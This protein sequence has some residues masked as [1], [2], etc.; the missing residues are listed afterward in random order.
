MKNSILSYVKRS[1]YLYVF[2]LLMMLGSIALDAVFP[3]ITRA[4]IDD[5]VIAGNIEILMRLLLAMLGIGAGRAVFQFLKEFTMD[6][7]SVKVGSELRCG[8]FKHIQKLSIRFFDKNNT[9]EL[10]ARVKDDV[11]AI[12]NTF[13][14]VGML[15]VECT[16]HT[17]IVLVCMVKISPV[18]TLVPVAIMP[19]VAYTAV[20]LE[21]KIGKVYDDMSEENAELTTVVQENLTG[22]RVVKAFARED[23]ELEKFDKHNQRYNDLCMKQA[24]VSLR[25]NP[26]IGF[27]TRLLLILVI[28]CGG[29]FVIRGNMSFGD[30]A[31]FTEYSNNIIWPMEMIGWLS[32]DL[33]SGFAS[34]KK[35]KKIF[36]ENPEIADKENAV[37]IGR[38]KGEIE[39]K[40][41][42]FTINETQVLE[43]V[44][45]KVE[46]GKTLGIMGVTGSGKTSVINLM[47][48]FYDATSGSI[49]IDGHDVKDVSLKS[50]RNNLSVVMQDVFL[51]SDSIRENITIGLKNK[52]IT[53]ELIESSAK[54]A[55]AAGFINKLAEKYETVVGERGVGLSGGQKQ[56]ISIA[57][58][59]AKKAPVLVLDD[60]TSAL[61]METE[62]E[63]Q[64]TLEAMKDTTKIIIAHRV[65]AVK[66]ADEIIVLSDGKIAERGTHDELIALG[67]KYYETYEAQCAAS[68]FLE[69]VSVDVC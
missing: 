33:A 51:F 50:L 36:A 41:V 62:F 44:S 43:D 34:A 59:I 65:S 61:D 45:F 8:L 53:D 5:V 57:R 4:I 2:S 24:K 17:V 38:A 15:A 69:E 25:Y 6:Y 27:L 52:K 56:R 16:I 11:D 3:F 22:V 12:W 68:N 30:L 54:A 49:M 35:I 13:G 48:R 39:F 10:M 58:A 18:L 47:E 67:G 26:N 28:L 55:R 32:A 42:S 23:Y 7:A 31:A 66:N 1:W 40:N 14:F 9:G 29:I 21:K 60:S 19:M 37:D 63:I 20:I 64:K 46:A